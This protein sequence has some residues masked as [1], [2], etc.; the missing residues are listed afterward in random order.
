M[1]PDEL[2]VPDFDG[3]EPDMDM[4]E[5]PEGYDEIPD[6]PIEEPDKEEKEPEKGNTPIELPDFPDAG[7]EESESSFRENTAKKKADGLTNP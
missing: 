2:N 4:E 6:S 3:E 1:E 5:P 7:D